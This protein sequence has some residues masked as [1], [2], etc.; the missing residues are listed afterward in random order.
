MTQARTSFK[1]MV[2]AAKSGDLQAADLVLQRIWPDRKGK[3]LALTEPLPTAQG[4]HGIR[5]RL[6]GSG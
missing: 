6:D 4:R 3:A 1:T 5:R 2:E